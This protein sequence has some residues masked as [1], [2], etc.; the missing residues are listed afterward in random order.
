[1]KPIH[2]KYDIKEDVERTIARSGLHIDILRGKRFFVTGGTGFFGVWLLS[3]LVE[4]K[5]RLGGNLSILAL[6]RSPDEFLKSHPDKGFGEH[7]NF[8]TGDV[9]TFVLNDQPITHLVHMAATNA[10]ETFAG[11]D[12]LKKL[13]MLYLGTRNVIEQCGHSLES[14]LFTSSGVA[15][16]INRNE[17][18]REVDYSGPNTTD[19]GSALGLGKLVAEYLISYYAQKFGYSYSIARCFAFAGPYLP[20]DL[21]YAFGNFVQNAIDGENIHIKGDGQ[22][23]RSYLYIGDAI[24]WLLRLLGSPKNDVYNVGSVRAI[25]ISELAGKIAAQS[26]ETLEVVIHGKNNVVGNFRRASYVPS[27][28]KILSD[29]PG[30]EEWTSI[31]EMIKKMLAVKPAFIV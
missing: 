18:L 8:L 25:S 7:I 27:T 24:A 9:K 6:S 12:Q 23:L 2:Y 15:Y 4:I 21:H 31:D 19:L 28:E 11:E 5:K 20:L 22:D 3:A 17:L 30:L 14:V 10:G 16:G 29:C 1:M 13:D 26:S